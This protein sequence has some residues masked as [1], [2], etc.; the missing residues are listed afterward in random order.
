MIR[1]MSVENPL[2]GAPRI[3]GEL[4]TLGF[5]V[6][7]SSVPSTW[8]SVVDRPVRGG[9]P[10]CETT[11]RT[12]LPWICSWSDDWLQTA[13]WLCDRA[14][15]SQRSRMDQR[16]SQPD[17]GVGCTPNHRGISLGWGSPLYDPGPRSD[18][19]RH[20]HTPIASNGHS[21]Q[22]DC[23]SL[24][25]A[26]WLCRTNYRIDPARVFGPHHCLG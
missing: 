14:A 21:G 20:R 24:A 11:L 23:T 2:W 12:L 10:F 5:S 6:A 18:L 22:T 15:S 16:H 19:R 17:S 13:V 7:Q 25:L 9:R 4:L 3:H 26:E 1:R 8:S